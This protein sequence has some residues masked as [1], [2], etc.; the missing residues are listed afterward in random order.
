MYEIVAVP[1]DTP[2]TTPV[3]APIVATEVLEHVQVPPVMASDNVVVPPVPTVVLP[4]IADGIA[5][6]VTVLVTVLQYI[7]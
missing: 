1:A 5:F 2:V 6:T 4:I 3:K 7:V